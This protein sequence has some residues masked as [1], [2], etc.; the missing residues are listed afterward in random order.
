MANFI[1]IITQQLKFEGGF[2]NN[3]A[4]SGGVTNFGIAYNY[5]KDKFSSPDDVKNMTQD[6][7]VAF[8]KK[9]YWQ[10][11]QGDAITDQGVAQVLFNW[12]CHHGV[13]GAIH[14]M[15]KV[16]NTSFGQKL[17]VDGVLGNLSL[18][19]INSVAPQALIK[20]YV[21][22]N[23]DYL[24]NMIAQDPS[25]QVF[26]AGWDNRYKN[27]L[28]I[29]LNASKTVAQAGLSVAQA[30]PLALALFGFFVSA[31]FFFQHAQKSV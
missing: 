24:K 13:N 19:A 29:A 22:F 23:Q 14:D 17:Q 4:D 20:A 21:F 3:P 28:T 9:Y 31:S 1:P 16:L 25:Q 2:V 18:S 7:A 8:Y 15:Q 12:A 10:P 11:I 26:E 30:H 6:Q 5:N 27:L